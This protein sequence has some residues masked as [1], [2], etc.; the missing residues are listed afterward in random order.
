MCNFILFHGLIDM[1]SYCVILW[2]IY[3]FIENLFQKHCYAIL[4]TLTN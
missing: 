1:V 4:L 2:K 3:L